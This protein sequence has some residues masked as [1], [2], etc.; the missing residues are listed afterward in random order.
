MLLDHTGVPMAA[1]WLGWLGVVPFV[2][3]AVLSLLAPP[4]AA[5]FA[6][7][8]LVVY[9]AVLLSFLGG[10]QWGLA[11]GGVGAQASHQVSVA[12]LGISVM[13]ALVGWCALLLP[14]PHGLVLL[15]GAFALVLMVD[16]RAPREGRAPPWYPHLRWPLTVTAMS[17]LMAGA[18]A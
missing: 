14:R 8:A 16:L 10:I 13:P 17:A 3:S 2:A 5:A 18:L 7:Q 4:A 15:A 6:A 9:G 1:R 11:I 12:R